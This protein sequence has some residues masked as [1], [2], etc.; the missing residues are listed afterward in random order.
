MQLYFSDETGDPGVR[1]GASACFGV[2]LLRV[3]PDEA[4]R[5]STVMRQVRKDLGLGAGHEFKWSRNRPS[6]RLAALQACSRQDFAYRARLWLKS[7]APIQAT[8]GKEMEARLIRSC[9]RDFGPTLSPARLYVDGL[10]DRERA[11][12]IRRTLAD[13][14]DS[15]GRPCIREVRLQDSASSDMLQLA[16]LLVGWSASQMP[17]DAQRP[18][19]GQAL[20]LRGSCL[21]WPS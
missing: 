8:A 15:Q 17:V 1:P 3:E 10:A 16:D 6:T 5:L 13:I 19:L 21:P 2:C 7:A 18:G 4:R 20:S 14:M 9:L 11:A 12:R